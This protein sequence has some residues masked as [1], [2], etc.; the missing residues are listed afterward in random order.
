MAVK[1]IVHHCRPKESVRRKHAVT[2]TFPGRAR[3]F[4]GRFLRTIPSGA[5]GK[6]TR[7][8]CASHRLLI[9]KYNCFL[10][11]LNSFS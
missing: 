10:I 9:A 6:K 3:R 8:G 7:V 11:S 1:P 4:A 5:L 2:H